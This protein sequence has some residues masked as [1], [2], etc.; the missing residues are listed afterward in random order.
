M[1]CDGFNGGD[2][3]S[4][5][6]LKSIGVTEKGVLSQLAHEIASPLMEYDSGGHV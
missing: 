5:D 3:F 1:Y 6:D 2:C 4:K